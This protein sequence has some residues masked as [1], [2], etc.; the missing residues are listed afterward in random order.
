MFLIVLANEIVKDIVNKD[1]DE[2]NNVNTLVVQFGEIAGKI[3]ATLTLLILIG[4]LG[5]FMQLF[6]AENATK[7]FVYL[8]VAVVVPLVAG[9]VFL[10]LA[11][12]KMQYKQ[13][14]ILLKI[15][16]VLGILSLPAFYLFSK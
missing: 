14:S 6:L 7:E 13:I 1:A 8:L 2:A 15:I 5:Y 3:A 16:T 11:K 9:I 10:F 12:Q 4:A